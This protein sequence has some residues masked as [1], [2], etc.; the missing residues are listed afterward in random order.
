MTVILCHS[1]KKSKHEYSD[2]IDDI[3]VEG[4][5]E[6]QESPVTSS[7]DDEDDD[8]DEDIAWDDDA[9]GPTL[10]V[11]MQTV[12]RN[13]HYEPFSYSD[14]IA[15]E[16]TG[17][18]RLTR[19]HYRRPSANLRHHKFTRKNT[20]PNPDDVLK[21]MPAL[22]TKLSEKELSDDEESSQSS[23]FHSRRHSIAT[24]NISLKDMKNNR[25]RNLKQYQR[26]AS[27]VVEI[28]DDDM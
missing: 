2:N 22:I 28:I 20:E 19:G 14:V 9:D 24:H 18:P 12:L 17:S 7:D 5:P 25:L 8:S 6:P 1:L 23:S 26:P 10:L 27:D 3:D 4:P 21:K 13:N 11:K 15:Y 16:S